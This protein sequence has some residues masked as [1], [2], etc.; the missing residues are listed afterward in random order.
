MPGG[1]RHKVIYLELNCAGRYFTG[2][3]SEKGS[4]PPS[5]WRHPVHKHLRW[6][7]SSTIF[8][9][10]LVGKT[11]PDSHTL[12]HLLSFLWTASDDRTRAGGCRVLQAI[13]WK[14]T[15]WLQRSSTVHERQD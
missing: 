5:P 12:Q 6:R 9:T 11:C 10:R 13:G 7:E 2:K 8:S 3:D 14:S 1:C 15:P 4:G